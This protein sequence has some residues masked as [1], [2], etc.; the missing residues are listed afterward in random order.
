[1]H[2]LGL[3]KAR[4]NALT[5]HQGSSLADKAPFGRGYDDT[6]TLAPLDTARVV[7]DITDKLVRR[8]TFTCDG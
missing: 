2:Q 8:Q 3:R 7:G 1:M 6:N 5:R 4:K